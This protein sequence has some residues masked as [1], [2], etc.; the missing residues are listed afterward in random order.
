MIYHFI[1]LAPHALCHS[2]ERRTLIT[3]DAPAVEIIG[4]QLPGNQTDVSHAGLPCPCRLLRGQLT[5]E[6]GYLLPAAQHLAPQSCRLDGRFAQTAAHQPSQQGMASFGAEG[7]EVDTSTMIVMAEAALVHLW[8]RT[9]IA[10]L[11]HGWWHS[12]TF[13]CLLICTSVSGKCS[14]MRA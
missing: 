3:R 8:D 12:F 2:I 7:D 14:A 10:A 11:V 1:I 6:G 13:L 5:L 9:T 4:H